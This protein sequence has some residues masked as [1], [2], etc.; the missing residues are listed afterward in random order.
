METIYNPH[1]HNH[2]E[3][4]DDRLQQRIT[5]LSE[6]IRIVRYTGERRAQV[7]RE[8]GIIAFEMSERLREAREQDIEEAWRQHGTLDT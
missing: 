4:S 8:M 1:E 5:T 2:I 6:N 3:W 7:E